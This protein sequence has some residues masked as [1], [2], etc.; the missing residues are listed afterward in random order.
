M[1][2]LV[3][4]PTL[5]RRPIG[6]ALLIAIVIV[7]AAVAVATAADPGD[8][9]RVVRVQDVQAI[10]SVRRLVADPAGLAVVGL[11][12]GDAHRFYVIQSPR[13]QAAV[14]AYSGAVLSM[15]ETDDMPT[16]PNVSV[17]EV[18]ALGRAD[19]YA[20]ANGIAVS[21]MTRSIELIDHGDTKEYAV[22]WTE[23]VNGARSPALRRIS[24]NPAT[25]EVFAFRNFDRSYV[26]PP[27]P[28]VSAAAADSA[29]RAAIGHPDATVTDT[30]LAI[31]F[32]NNGVQQLVYEISL[33]T[34]D[35]F[36]AIVRVDALSG[37]AT[38][39][40]RG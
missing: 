2:E 34:T 7:V 40:G 9:K 23:R 15:A 1:A 31:W 18:D 11:Q 12:D 3:R 20:R 16:T 8:P 32:D 17:S 26:P 29:A 33:A 37:V 35:G 36:V 14:D 39:V 19:A 30:D 38:I 6:I 21:G 5:G 25:G 10:A 28:K 4:K 22:T 13:V 24:L 27:E